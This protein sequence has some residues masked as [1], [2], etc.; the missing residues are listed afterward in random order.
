M[1]DAMN[2]GGLPGGAVCTN[3]DCTYI[4]DLT[5][6]MMIQQKSATTSL[7][8]DLILVRY[9]DMCAYSFISNSK[10]FNEP[11]LLCSSAGWILI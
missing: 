6:L 2:D 11:I 4:T 1:R 5:L 7:K 9:S 10:E 3:H 8:P